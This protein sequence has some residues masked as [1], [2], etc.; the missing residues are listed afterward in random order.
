MQTRLIVDKDAWPPEQLKTFTP[1]LLIQHKAHRNLKQSTAMAE[2]VEQGHIDKVASVITTDT[3]PKCPKLDTHQPLQEILDTSKV[4]KEVVEIL[5]PMQTS[6]DP[7]FILI[8]RA[9][10]IGKSF[11]LKEMAY[12]WGKQEILQKFKLVVHVRLR[13]LAVQKC[14]RLTTFSSHS[15]SE[16]RDL[17]KLSLL[18]VSTCHR[19]MVKI[20]LY[21]L[22]VMMNIL[23]G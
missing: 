4:T 2:F 11:L 14:H 13:N 22:M 17:V 19:I 6:S 20:L 3:L 16:T 10:G 15:V 5:A 12:R 23:K 21:S 1:L 18:I 8:E 9:P 7:Q